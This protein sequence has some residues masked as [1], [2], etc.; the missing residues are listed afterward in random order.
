MPR[1]ELNEHEERLKEYD[2]EIVVHNER[3]NCLHDIQAR[4]DHRLSLIESHLHEI[5]PR[6]DNL[7]PQVKELELI[8]I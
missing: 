1:E 8:L 7:E 5:E 6:L 4:V 2:K 3:L